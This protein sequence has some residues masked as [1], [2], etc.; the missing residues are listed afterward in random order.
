M[1]KAI[2]KH[3]QQLC[4]Y[5]PLLHLQGFYILLLM[6]HSSLCM[7][8]LRFCWRIHARGSTGV[9]WSQRDEFW[10][11]DDCVHTGSTSGLSPDKVRLSV[12]PVG[13]W[14][15]ILDK[16]AYMMNFWLGQPHWP[17][18]LLQTWL[19]SPP[20]NMITWLWLIRIHLLLLHFREFR[21]VRSFHQLYSSLSYWNIN[22][23]QN[24]GVI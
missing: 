24:K 2:V 10:L 11:T 21:E 6:C 7:L 4:K 9:F 3:F 16:P 18:M 20:H 22:N 1:F 12:Q 14:W 13:W 5:T 17:N 8:L 23:Y 19:K 15:L